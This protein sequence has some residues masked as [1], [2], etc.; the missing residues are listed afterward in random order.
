MARPQQNLFMK[1]MMMMIS[2]TFFN[3]PVV[4][5]RTMIGFPSSLHKVVL[6]ISIW[7]YT[8]DGGGGM[9]SSTLFVSGWSVGGGVNNQL[10]DEY[11][12]DLNMYQETT[13]EEWFG[14]SICNFCSLPI[15][16]CMLQVFLSFV[17][18][19]NVLHYLFRWHTQQRQY[20]ISSRPQH[21]SIL[22][23]NI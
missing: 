6:P 18:I 15:Y 12:L 4:D 22:N 17:F 11:T 14:N 1:C 16:M 19:Q 2:L 23:K 13:H 9:T 21:Y 5:A 7:L 10:V 8:N 20:V 3:I